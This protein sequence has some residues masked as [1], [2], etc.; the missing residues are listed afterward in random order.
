[1]II[2]TDTTIDRVN[3]TGDT[4]PVMAVIHRTRVYCVKQYAPLDAAFYK[5]YYRFPFV[6]LKFWRLC[7]VFPG[8]PEQTAS[9]RI[10]GCFLCL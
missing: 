7:E 3:I 6:N 10:T 2:Q 9:L 4:I 5:S 1:V 8:G